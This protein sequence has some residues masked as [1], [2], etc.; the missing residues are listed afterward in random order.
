MKIALC[1]SGLPRMIEQTCLY[2]K[3]SIID[4]Y[5]T[6]VFIHTWKQDIYTRNMIESM[7]HPMLLAIQTPKKFN[8]SIY[9]DRVWPH[10]TT[11]EGVLSQWCSVNISMQYWPFWSIFHLHSNYDIIVRARFDWYLE[12][13]KFEINDCVNVANTP[14]LSGHK[15]I[16]EGQEHLGISDQFAYGNPIVMNTYSKLFDNIPHLYQDKKVDFCSELLLKAHLLENNIG[17]KEHKLKNGITRNT[18]IVP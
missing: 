12:S 13:I 16:Y 15:F 10:R 5:D 4:R 7:Y 6:D 9:T 2:W 18:G 8:T 11:P 3:E 1:F 14:G 17:V